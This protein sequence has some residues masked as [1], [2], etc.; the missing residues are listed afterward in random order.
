MK[1]ISLCVWLLSR[2]LIHLGP[3]HVAVSGVR[4]P[5]CGAFTGQGTA[6][7]PP[8]HQHWALERFPVVGDDGRS[9]CEQS[10]TVR[11]V[12]V[13]LPFSWADTQAQICRVIGQVYVTLVRC[14]P[15]V[16]QGGC[17]T[18]RPGHVTGPPDTHSVQWFS[19]SFTGSHVQLS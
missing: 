7:G 3:V 11:R 17:S 14:C 6:T 8:V 10:Q 9:C 16:L 5:H 2:G 13:C 12:D 15:T 19:R 4:P 1:S 18:F